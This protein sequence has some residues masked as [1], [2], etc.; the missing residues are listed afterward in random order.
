MSYVE[1]KFEGL[2]EIINTLERMGQSG[3]I[4]NVE[5]ELIIEATEEAKQTIKQHF[6]RSRDYHK[7][8]K[9]GYRPTGHFVDNIP[10]TDIKKTRSGMYL[11]IGAKDE[12]DQFF[13]SKFPNFGTSRQPPNFAFEYAYESAKKCLNQQG[14]EKFETLLQGAFT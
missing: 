4:E 8:G 11:T 9:K 10:Q 5:K 14:I 3:E 2:N 13:Y 12:Y 6:N 1:M 7:S